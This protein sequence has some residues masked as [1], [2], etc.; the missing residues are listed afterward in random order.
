MLKPLLSPLST[1]HLVPRAATL[2]VEI[3]DRSTS[4]AGLVKG[5][6]SGGIDPPGG[7]AFGDVL[8]LA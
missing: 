4:P 3:N 6:R 8:G 7:S 5:E 1:F 2:D